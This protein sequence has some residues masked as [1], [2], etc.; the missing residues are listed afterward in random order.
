MMQFGMPTLVEN[1]TLE[2]NIT[3]CNNL[4][5]NFIELNMNFPEYQIQCLEQTDYLFELAKKAGIYYTIHLDENL[6]IADFNSLVSDAYLETVRRSIEVAKNLLPLRD[7]NGD[8]SQPLSLNMHMHHGIYIT[9]PDRKVQMYDRNFDTY[10]NSFSLFRSKCEEWIGDSEVMIA[11][12]NTD[13]F[14][15]YEKKAI[16]FLLES[17]KFGLTWDIG[18]SKATGEKDVP[19]IMHH[20]EKLIH[21]HIHDGWEAP[22]KNHLA[23]GDGEIDLQ[24]RMRLA[25]E[26]NA[27][28][29][30]ETKTIE[31][32]KKSVGWLKERRM[33]SI[34]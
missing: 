30:I 5:L 31:A 15:E 14:R 6:N 12:E 27:R 16:E 26:R 13:G 9:L 11:V 18:H 7:L 33:M 22:P 8:I 20:R 17:P 4:G 32:L 3:L 19:F 23:L 34:R 21:F 2:E 1:H 29:V 28:C 25:K 10:M 24:G